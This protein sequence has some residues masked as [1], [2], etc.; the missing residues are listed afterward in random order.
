MM[1]DYDTNIW[2]FL[3]ELKF[4]PE[5]SKQIIEILRSKGKTGYMHFKDYLRSTFH[6]QIVDYMET[7]EKEVESMLKT[8]KMLKFLY[9]KEIIHINSKKVY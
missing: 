2:N 6:E 5:K 3:K 7:K 1:S 8:S 4:T 9:W